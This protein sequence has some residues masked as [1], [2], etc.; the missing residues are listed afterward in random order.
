M[1]II[2]GYITLVNASLNIQNRCFI[3][4]TKLI[5]QKKNNPL[6]KKQKTKK[7]L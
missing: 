3:S 7:K 1:N 6:E 2:K 5:I 4:N